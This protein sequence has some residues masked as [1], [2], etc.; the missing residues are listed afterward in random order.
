MFLGAEEFVELICGLLG[1]GHRRDHFRA[2]ARRVEFAR[3]EVRMVASKT[4]LL[5]TLATT[6]DRNRRSSLC[7]EMAER[8]GFEPT[9]SF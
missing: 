6:K 4:D 1:G 5:R 2:L 9:R 3:R 7:A 8:M